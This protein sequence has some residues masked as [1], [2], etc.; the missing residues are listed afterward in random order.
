MLDGENGPL[1]SYHK[2]CLQF[3][4]I[5]I[6]H[7]S[8]INLHHAGE[9][10]ISSTIVSFKSRLRVYKVAYYYLT[11]PFERNTLMMCNFRRSES[12]SMTQDWCV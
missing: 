7:V 5:S 6:E 3:F 1:R 9:V 12:R 2:Y 8:K 4:H 10:I 11:M